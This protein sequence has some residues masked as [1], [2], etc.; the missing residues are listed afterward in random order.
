[1]R[2]I[3]VIAARRSDDPKPTSLD[4]STEDGSLDDVSF[5]DRRNARPY[6]RALI[7]PCKKFISLPE[8][9]C[10]KAKILSMTIT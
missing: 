1:M 8:R 6:G 9:P 7:W 3:V 10:T 2:L 4:G 5:P